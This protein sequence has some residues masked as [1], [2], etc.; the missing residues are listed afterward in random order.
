MQRLLEFVR[1]DDKAYANTHFLKLQPKTW[2]DIEDTLTRMVADLVATLKKA[3]LMY[4]CLSHGS[5]Q[6]WQCTMRCLSTGAAC[7]LL[8]GPDRFGMV[9]NT[10]QA[11]SF[12]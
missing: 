4:V 5:W 3:A 7:S 1:C 9:Q 2:T 8:A 11:T 10:F 12:H 6:H